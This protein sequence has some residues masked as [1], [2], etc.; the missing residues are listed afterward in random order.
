MNIINSFNR[1]S[2]ERKESFIIVYFKRLLLDFIINNNIF[3]R[4]VTTL[5]FKK[6]LKYL[7]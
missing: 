7:N 5:S 2:G 6:L 3:F 1:V 4:T